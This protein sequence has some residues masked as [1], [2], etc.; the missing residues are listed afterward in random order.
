MLLQQFGLTREEAKRLVLELP[1]IAESLAKFA[2]TLP[3]KL[4][5]IGNAMDEHENWLALIR[6]DQ[7][8][9][10]EHAGLEPTVYEGKEPQLKK[11]H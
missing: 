7:R 5:G 3:V 2:K 11:T 8:R 9:L 1:Q 4:D 6:A 10:L